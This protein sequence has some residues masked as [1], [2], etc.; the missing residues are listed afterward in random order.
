VSDT[1]LVDFSKQT[2]LSTLHLEFVP[3]DMVMHW[4]RCGLAAD[5][6]AAHLAYAFE[7]R[8]SVR[9]I[10]S[11]VIN[12]L[13]ENAA[14]FALEK[15]GVASIT[16]R[17]YGDQIAIETRNRADKRR[18]DG[19]CSLFDELANAPVE[20]LFLARIS[21]TAEAE[22]SSSGLGL[23]VLR[24]DYGV[25]LGAHIAALA[26]GSGFEVTVQ[27]LLRTDELEER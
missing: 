2:P 10:L 3:L 9:P 23:L 17:H 1:S 7:H 8:D 21:G 19:I 27:A 26:E 18:A 24:K 13:L 11:T 4:H 25:R 6:F 15:S 16:V 20:D 5:Y 22:G 12:E 14:K